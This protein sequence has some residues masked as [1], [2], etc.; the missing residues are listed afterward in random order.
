MKFL[1]VLLFATSTLCQGLDLVL[2][3]GES[4]PTKGIGFQ[5]NL[6]PEGRRTP[7]TSQKFESVLEKYPNF[8]YNALQDSINKYFQTIPPKRKRPNKRYKEQVSTFDDRVVAFLSPELDGIV[9]EKLPDESERW[10]DIGYYLAMLELAGGSTLN[11]A[12]IIDRW[13]RGSE[14]AQD[15]VKRL[16]RGQ[17]VLWAEVVSSRSAAH[18]QIFQSAEKNDEWRNVVLD[19]YEE[20]LNNPDRPVLPTL[21]DEAPK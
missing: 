11:A 4:K 20:F 12:T 14:V 15:V 3:S 10:V 2:V 16:E 8:D 17:F 7:L 19:A 5:R 13:K 18:T 21:P 9:K 6:R 1:S